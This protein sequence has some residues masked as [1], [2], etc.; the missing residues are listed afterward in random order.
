MPT[1]PVHPGP[2]L[3]RLLGW[4]ALVTT[5]VIQAYGLYSPSPPGP[6]GVP[7]LDKVGHLLAFAVPTGLAWLLGARW[8]VALLAVHAVVSEPLQHAVAEQRMLDWWDAVAN[9]TGVALGV[10]LALALGVA[11]APAARR[12]TGHDGTRPSTEEG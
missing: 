2:D 8:L 12:R 7:G 6:D 1:A 3:V 9:L 11:L 5:L 10:G 4:S